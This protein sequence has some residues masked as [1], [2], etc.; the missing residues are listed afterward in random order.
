MRATGRGEKALI[1]QVDKLM[2]VRFWLT[3][4]RPGGVGTQ[5]RVQELKVLRMRDIFGVAM[6]KFYPIK[7]TARLFTR[8]CIVKTSV[9][10]KGE[11]KVSHIADTILV[12]GRGEDKEGKGKARAY[13]RY[14]TLPNPAM[15]PAANDMTYIQCSGTQETSSRWQR[16]S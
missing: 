6:M 15:L 2:F 4:G 12:W 3:V 14:F 5:R 13:Y 10:W 16:V 11:Q 8:F 7:E 1:F 9:K